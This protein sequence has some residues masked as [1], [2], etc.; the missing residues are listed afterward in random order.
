[1]NVQELKHILSAFQIDT[2]GVSYEPVGHGY[3]NDT[4]FVKVQG[5][6]KYVC[7]RINN[8]VFKAVENLQENVDRA[9]LKLKGK[10]YQKMAFLKTTENKS[11]LKYKG[12][13][14]RI[15]PFIKNSQIY[16][17]TTEPKVAF[18]AGAIIGLFHKLLNNEDITLYHEII[19]DFHNLKVRISQFNAAM[20]YADHLTH[21]EAQDQVNFV[22]STIPVFDYL[23]EADLPLRLCHNDTKLNN[24][25]FNDQNEGLC[26]IDLDTIMPGY[27]HYDFSDAIRTIV[28]PASED[29]TNLSKIEFDLILFE[30]FLNGLK[31]SGLKLTNSEIEYLP[32]SVA[33]MPF[34]HGLRALTDYLNGNT[35]YK[36]NYAE[37]NLDRCKNLFEFT[38]LAINN[39]PN[40]KGYVNLIKK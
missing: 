34:L 26:L 29:E 28:N 16:N 20:D 40:M 22:F 14:W 37:H 19:P 23:N 7:Q 2:A 11:L 18:E 31:H 13:F 3:I 5:N 4:F 12:T 21:T 33:Y 24:I 17:T 38:R 10:D 36:V 35:Y 30:S 39:V 1:M 25:L 6:Y 27:F 8:N 32:L 15:M 9:L